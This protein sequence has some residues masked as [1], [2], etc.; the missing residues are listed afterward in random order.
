MQNLLVVTHGNWV[1][2][3]PRQNCK[4]SEEICPQTCGMLGPSVCGYALVPMNRSPVL[5]GQTFWPGAKGEVTLT[6]T[7]TG[8]AHQIK[9]SFPAD[10]ADENTCFNGQEGGL[11]KHCGMLRAC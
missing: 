11:A 1:P 7:S 8:T 6:E 4:D 9:K 2:C 5:P 3:G 10:W